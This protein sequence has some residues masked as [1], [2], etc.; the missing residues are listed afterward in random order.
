MTNPT[1][2][3]LNDSAQEQGSAK[4]KIHLEESLAK[5]FVSEVSERDSEKFSNLPPS[6][7][8][9]ILNV[10]LHNPQ[11][12]TP[13][14]TRHQCSLSN[15]RTKLSSSSRRP[16]SPHSTT[17]SPCNREKSLQFQQSLLVLIHLHLLRRYFKTS[18]QV[19]TDFCHRLFYG[20]SGP[21]HSLKK[22]LRTFCIHVGYVSN[23][24]FESALLAVKMHF[25]T[26]TFPV[27]S[28]EFSQLSLLSSFF[29]ADLSS[30]FL[31]VLTDSFD[32]EEFSD[33]SHIIS[34]LE[35]ELNNHND[36]DFLHKCSD[37]FPNLKELHVVV[38]TSVVVRVGSIG[39]EGVIALADALAI[40]TSVTSID[41]GYNSIGDNGARVLANALKVNSTITSLDL[42]HNSIGDIGAR[43]L[44]NALNVNATIT[45]FDL[46][47]NW[48]T[49]IG[50]RALANALKVNSTITNFDLGHNPI[51]DKGARALANALK[52]NAKI[53]SIN[54]GRN[55]IGDTGARALTDALRVNT[56]VTSI[57]LGHNPIGDICVT[58][59]T[60]V[61][62]NTVKRIVVCQ[63]FVPPIIDSQDRLFRFDNSTIAVFVGVFIVLLLLERYIN[64]ESS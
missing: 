54:L 24:F 56:S 14:Q 60:N 32:V 22:D 35:L 13:P 57:D 34:G 18:I 62:S 59:L 64:R 63:P 29:E 47:H 12:S 16:S 42:G 6:D 27:I 31:H 20:R 23:H 28:T 48:I 40:N 43:V 46:G 5:P 30:I 37:F 7:E 11:P 53:K 26:N 41:V 58:A 61:H 15:G 17:E 3:N 21:F 49:D 52:V 38:L 45:S 50:V 2:S 8:E 39:A 55:N 10:T 44:A 51:G 33:Y 25:Q 36:L 1:T 19:N 9:S 4:P